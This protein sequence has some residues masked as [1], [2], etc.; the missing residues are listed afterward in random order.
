MVVEPKHPCAFASAPARSARV[1][2]EPRHPMRL[3]SQGKV[4]I[5]ERGKSAAE[6]CRANRGKSAADRCRANRGKSAADSVQSIAAK[7]PRIGADRSAAKLPRMECRTSQTNRRILRVEQRGKSAAVVVR[8]SAPSAAAWR[9][10]GRSAAEF[11]ARSPPR[12]GGVSPRSGR[13]EGGSYA[14]ILWRSDTPQSERRYPAARSAEGGRY[15][16][17]DRFPARSRARQ[18]G[19]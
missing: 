8:R 3:T 13:K 6:R 15:P 11:A 17:A 1:V 2:V 14:A 10:S 5:I 9:A 16:A 4:R 19:A 18:R 7:V 12:R